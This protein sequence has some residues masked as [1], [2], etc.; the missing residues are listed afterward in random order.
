MKVVSI[1]LVLMMGFPAFAKKE[2][3][4]PTDPSLN[5]KKGKSSPFKSGVSCDG[6]FYTQEEAESLNLKNCEIKNRLE[7]EP[8]I[9]QPGAAPSG[10]NRQFSYELF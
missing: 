8:Y 3:V 6:F 2:L 7:A 4:I 10:N 1:F 9:Q 5:G